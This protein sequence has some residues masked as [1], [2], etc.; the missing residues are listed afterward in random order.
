MGLI[1]LQTQLKRK[2]MITIIDTTSRKSTPIPEGTVRPI[3]TQSND[4]TRVEVIKYE[5]ASGKTHRVPPSDRTQVVYILE[6]KGAEVT[7]TKAGQSA[8]HTGQ[9]GSGVY[10]EPTEEAAIKA[11]GTP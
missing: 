1:Q 8:V 10:L 4:K 6:G 7:F 5:V 11:S 2:L 9:R 3:L